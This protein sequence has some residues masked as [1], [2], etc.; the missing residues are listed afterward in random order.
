MPGLL[1]KEIR[2]RPT[3]FRSATPESFALDDRT[4]LKQFAHVPRVLVHHLRRL[5][6]GRRES[7]RING[8]AEGGSRTPTSFRTTDFKSRDRTIT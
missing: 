7:S 5:P 4:W 3:S 2:K 8:G 1:L 6:L